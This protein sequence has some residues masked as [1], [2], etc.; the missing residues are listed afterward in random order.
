MDEKPAQ[1]S[2]LEDCGTEYNTLAQGQQCSLEPLNTGIEGPNG[3]QCMQTISTSF[4]LVLF[5]SCAT[6]LDKTP[7][8]VS[9]YTT[10]QFS[11]A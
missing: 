4:W 10:I 6:G 3:A 2:K 7:V 5:C 9:R 8:A 11:V 1:N